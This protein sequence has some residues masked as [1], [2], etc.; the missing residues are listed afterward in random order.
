MFGWGKSARAK[1]LSGNAARWEDWPETLNVDD[2]ADVTWIKQS[3]DP[4]VWHDAA[5][6]CLIFRGDEHGLL[7]WLARQDTRDRVTAAAMFLHGSNGVRYLEE[8][9]VEGNYHSRN[10]EQNI[11]EMLDIL[12]DLDRQRRLPRN[13]IGLLPEWEEARRSTLKQLRGNPRA[14]MKMLR[15]ASGRQRAQMPYID[16]GEGELTSVPYLRGEFAGRL[17]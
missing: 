12:C 13:G 15:S 11:V 1:S 6:A 10:A 4:L 3:N 7:P 5:L 8:G 16:M 2:I 14:P 17:F 9:R